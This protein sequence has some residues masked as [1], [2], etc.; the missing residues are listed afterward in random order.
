[1]KNLFFITC[2][3]TLSAHVLADC[4]PTLL[5]GNRL[6]KK[7]SAAIY[8]AYIFQVN[9]NQG[10]EFRELNNKVNDLFDKPLTP[11]LIAEAI[12]QTNKAKK[13]CDSVSIK[14]YANSL[15]AEIDAHPEI[16]KPKVI[17]PPYS[18]DNTDVDLVRGMMPKFYKKRSAPILN[19]GLIYYG[20]YYQASDLARV[21]ALL[22]KRWN[23]S[24]DQALTL[25]TV[26]QSVIPFKHNILNYPDYTQAHVTDPERLQRL[27][28]YDNV[29]S[30]ILEEVYLQVKASD[31]IK[32]N[33]ANIDALV[34]VT[35]AQFDAL[36][37]A[38][39]RVAVTE[40]PMEI[41]WGLPG[42]G[43]V[44][45]VTD[46]RV[47][48]ELIHEIGHTL[49]LD[50]TANQCNGLDYRAA[51][52]C[53]ALSPSRDDVMSYC[54]NR[55]KVDENFFNKF[56]ACNLNIIKNKIVP[57]MLS[58]GAWAIEGREKCE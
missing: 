26:F 4:R 14:E 51:Q 2:L 12:I 36:G 40:N 16:V 6:Q 34:I 8:G 45:L 39:G 17:V 7:L 15:A 18:F 55:A 41:A 35:G 21:Q 54:R 9:A 44:E 42:G 23:I 38:S 53:C 32:G 24:T 50:H 29:G 47:V 52:A 31:E 10:D 33:L 46:E 49:F 58:G 25:N 5:Q 43:S 1:M 30:R 27:W 37:F 28:Y 19:I 20:D 22:E 56:E 48:D 13:F 3:L 11:V 57:A